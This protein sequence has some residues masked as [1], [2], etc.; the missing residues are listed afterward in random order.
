M[1]FITTLG[2]HRVRLGEF[3]AA[4]APLDTYSSLD[5]MATVLCADP[6]DGA[7]VAELAAQHVRDGGF[8]YPVRVVDGV[9][10]NGCHRYSALRSIDADWIDL[11]IA[12]DEHPDPQWVA[13]VPC[14]RISFRYWDQNARPRDLD[15]LVDVVSSAAGSFPTEDRWMN[16]DV[17]S[18]SSGDVLHVVLYCS[19]A[20]AP[21]AT[22]VMIERLALHGVGSELLGFSEVPSED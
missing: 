15:D 5:E 12:D 10:A 7:I 8:Q 1:D 14:T 20:E 13:P 16:A 11:W 3:T 4:V 19:L 6:V 22:V 2:P 18:F 21:A 9:L 17:V